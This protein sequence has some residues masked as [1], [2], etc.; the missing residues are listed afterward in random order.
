MKIKN[1]AGT[2][3]NVG[4]V[5]L[6]YL[7]V[8]E[9]RLNELKTPPEYEYS[10]TLLFPKEPNQFSKYPQLEID[11]VRAAIMAATKMKFPNFPKGVGKDPRNPLQEW[12]DPLKDGDVEMNADGEPVMPG[13][14]TLRTAAK[15]KYK[16]LLIDGERNK[17]L[18]ASGWQ[19]GDWGIVQISLFSYDKNK[20]AQGVS[21]GIRAIQF[22]FRDKALGG[23]S[24]SPNDFDE[25]EGADM[26]SDPLSE[27]DPHA[28]E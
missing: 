20:S 7:N 15:E 10:V 1:E 3:I 18:A 11:G 24:A 9:T 4:P 19:S 17:V 23:A 14:W 28:D 26:V 6:S 2:L 16:P 25:V 5:R 13:Y 21:A 8:F 22:L 12:W 27:Y